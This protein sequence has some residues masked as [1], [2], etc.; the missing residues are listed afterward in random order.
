MLAE[1]ADYL[2]ENGSVRITIQGHADERGTREYNLALGERRASA[3]RDYLQSMGVASSQ[4]R[5]VSYGEERPVDPALQ[6]IRLV[7]KSPRG[8][9]VLS[10]GHPFARRPRRRSIICLPEPRRRGSGGEGTTPSLS[11]PAPK[12]SSPAVAD[13]V[14]Y[15]RHRSSSSK[16]P[17]SPPWSP[18][19][20][21]S[22]SCRRTQAEVMM[23]RGLVETKRALERLETAQRD[24]YLDLDRH[25]ARLSGLAPATPAVP[26]APVAETPTIA[27]PAAENACRQEACNEAA[28]GLTRDKRFAEA[29]PAFEA[30]D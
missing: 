27:T 7:E 26:S 8:A 9:R 2:K 3:V 28:F 14:P 1:H 20:W 16:H 4:L 25:I 15:R 29:I 13:G 5:I 17:R 30:F 21:F 6:R 18:P 22:S 11:R 12:A 19:G 10:D 23:L 24:R